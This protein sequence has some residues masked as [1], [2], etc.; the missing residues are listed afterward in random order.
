MSM[1]KNLCVIH[2]FLLILQEH[3]I[4]LDGTLREPENNDETDNALIEDRDRLLTNHLGA[5]FNVVL[6][7]HFR[8]FCD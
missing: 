6:V 3:G 4:N 1:K 2:A 5:L 8:W 7:L